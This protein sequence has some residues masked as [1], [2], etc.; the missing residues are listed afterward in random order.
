[1]DDYHH[2]HR[3]RLV[4]P[5][6]HCAVASKVQLHSLPSPFYAPRFWIRRHVCLQLSHTLKP[7]F[8]LL[9]EIAYE[10]LWLNWTSFSFKWFIFPR[11]SRS[12]I[13]FQSL[14]PSD[15]WKFVSWTSRSCL[16]SFYRVRVFWIDQSYVDGICPSLGGSRGT[17]LARFMES[18]R[19]QRRVT[20]SLLLLYNVVVDH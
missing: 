16:F 7:R 17:Y 6:W 11:V 5:L 18:L 9:L 10:H 1:M 13:D 12:W 19:Q 3:P 4:L 14:D 20:S 8:R 15:D 2:N